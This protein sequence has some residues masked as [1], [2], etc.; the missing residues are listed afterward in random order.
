MPYQYFQENQ[1]L[2][3]VQSAHDKFNWVVLDLRI[4]RARGLCLAT[5]ADCH[6]QGPECHW[7]ISKLLGGGAAP[8]SGRDEVQRAL[9]V[10]RPF[11][12]TFAQ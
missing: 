11:P 10:S 3:F 5:G 4:Y 9:R 1:I 7:S 12:G 6:W 8:S 2:Q